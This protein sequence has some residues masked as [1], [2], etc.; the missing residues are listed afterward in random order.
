MHVWLINEDPSS[1]ILL[2]ELF[3]IK[4]Y[5][6]F[7]TLE[8]RQEDLTYMRVGALNTHLLLYPR[9]SKVHRSLRT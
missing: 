8:R 7:G 4:N 3:L 6:F 2:F 1:K 5:P 9:F